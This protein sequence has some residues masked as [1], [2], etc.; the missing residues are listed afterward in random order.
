MRRVGSVLLMLVCW[1]MLAAYVDSPLLPSPWAVVKEMSRLLTERAPYRHLLI[2]F[3]RGVVGL[4]LAL[5]FGI[6]AG[7]LCGLKK[8]SMEIISPLVSALQGCPTIVWVSLLMVWVG[9]GSVVPIVAIAVATFPVIFLNVAHGVSALDKRL[10]VMSRLYHVAPVRTLRDIV[11][12]GI[13]SYLLA[14]FAFSASICWK[15]ASTAE[16]IGSES[17]VGSQIY[18]AYHDLNIP[19]LFCWALILILF[20]LALD[21]WVIKPL[22]HVVSNQ[23]R[24]ING[25]TN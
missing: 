23:K 13:S 2:S 6:L 5:V 18:W 22:Q 10:L 4:T 25:Q 8:T 19:R 24:S 7:V 11:F 15:V 17:G 21:A 16:F 12:P 3:F 14:G 1:S 9:I 20:A